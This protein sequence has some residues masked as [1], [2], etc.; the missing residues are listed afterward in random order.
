MANTAFPA[1]LVLELNK[2]TFTVFYFLCS[3]IGAFTQES[4]IIYFLLGTLINTE[5]QA[6][7]VGT[8]PSRK[9]FVLL[10]L[11]IPSVEVQRTS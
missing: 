4:Y 1:R 8:A 2:H 5:D 9:E 7:Q 10:I 3:F 11:T 6:E